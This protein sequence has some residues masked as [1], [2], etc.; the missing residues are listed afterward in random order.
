MASLTPQ[1][2]QLGS[3]SQPTK[4]HKPWEY[5]DPVIYPPASTHKQTI[6]LLHGRGS[7]ASKFAPPLLNTPTPAGQTLQLAFPH[8]KLV[9]LTASRNRAI[10][11]KKSYTHQWF[12]NWH[13]EAKFVRQDLQVDGLSRSVAYVHGV[14]RREIEEVGREKV[15]VWG[16]SQGCATTLMSGLMWDGEAFGG[17]VGMCGYLPFSN[18]VEDVFNPS[19]AQLDLPI[20]AVTTIH[21]ELLLTSKPSMAFQSIPIF[22]GH[23]TKDD[24]VALEYGREAKK[25]LEQLGVDVKMTEYEGLGHWYSGEMLEDIFEFLREKLGVIGE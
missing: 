17:M 1:P 6:I 4:K 14:M 13:M 7:T 22:L 20:Q 2:P 25:A 5:P 12:D 3:P 19:T 24:K 11:Y 23:G 10:I 15:V 16:L 9:F 18:Y 21:D 8:A